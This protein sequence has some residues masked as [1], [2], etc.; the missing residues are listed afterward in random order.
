MANT[1]IPINTNYPN[2]SF[3][4]TSEENDGMPYL[5][6]VGAPITSFHASTHGVAG[7]DPVSLEISQV[8]GLQLELNAKALATEVVSSITEGNG[9]SASASIG[10]VTLAL[11]AATQ[12]SLGKADTALQS[13]PSDVVRTVSFVP[14]TSI[15]FDGNGGGTPYASGYWKSS[16][17]LYEY[18]F[19]GGWTKWRRHRLETW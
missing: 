10:G 16:D 11:S 19:K 7:D 1:R 18:T 5:P 2:A 4:P 8:V 17:S 13:L 3:S 12:T 14:A 15:D 9:I 6:N